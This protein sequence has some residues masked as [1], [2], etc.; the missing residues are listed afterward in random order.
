VVAIPIDD[1]LQSSQQGLHEIPQVIPSLKS[2][3]KHDIA[4]KFAA[5]YFRPYNF[6]SFRQVFQNCFSGLGVKLF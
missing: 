4:D 2:C 3:S 5:I 6:S 1:G